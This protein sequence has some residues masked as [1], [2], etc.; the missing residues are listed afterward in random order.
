M[1]KSHFQILF[2]VAADLFTQSEIA[3]TG[4]GG[5]LD[6][7]KIQDIFDPTR[8]IKW[9]IQSYY[10]PVTGQ[11]DAPG[12]GSSL[13]RLTLDQRRRTEAVIDTAKSLGV[14]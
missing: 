14:F 10:D 6:H 9:R 2:L 3:C 12:F 7:F 8:L 5:F 13:E 1:Q 4:K 11:L